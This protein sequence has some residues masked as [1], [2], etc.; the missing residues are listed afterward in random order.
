M[1]SGEGFSEASGTGREEHF[2]YVS[3][4][5]EPCHNVNGTLAEFR[6]SEHRSRHSMDSGDVDPGG[7]AGDPDAGPRRRR[8]LS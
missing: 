3:G 8:E 7:P 4:A 1:S 2:D 5:A 6:V